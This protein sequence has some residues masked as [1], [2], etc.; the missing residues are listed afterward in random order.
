MSRYLLVKDNIVANTIELEEGNYTTQYILNDRGD[1][2]PVTTNSSGQLVVSTTKY[3]IP[4]NHILVLSDK[5]SVGDAY[6][7][8][9]PPVVETPTTVGE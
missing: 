6:P 5:G 9:E 4:D 3:L 7:L 8:V 1:R 2:L